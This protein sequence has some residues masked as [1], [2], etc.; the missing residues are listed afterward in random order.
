MAHSAK[1]TLPE[2]GAF[3]RRMGENYRVSV[4]AIPAS[5]GYPN[6]PLSQRLFSAV[7][8]RLGSW[9]GI[10]LLL[11]YQRPLI[12]SQKIRA[13]DLELYSFREISA[14]E[15]AIFSQDSSLRLAK[16][17]VDK[18]K[19]RGDVCV[20]VFDGDQLVAYRWY[21]LSGFAPCEDNL[22]VRNSDPCH[23]Y[24]Y[25]MYTEPG[26]RGRRLQLSSMI[27]G[28][29]R[30]IERGFTHATYYVAAHNISS[31][32]GLSRI[33]DKKFVGIVGNVKL[34]GH[35][36]VLN[37]PNLDKYSFR[38]ENNDDTNARTPTAA[39]NLK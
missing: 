6:L 13:Q 39:T 27:Y 5:T 23:V 34:L 2:S 35:N 26:H 19:E 1:Q 25:K 21:A 16:N 15:L 18:A 14:L 10:K 30:M 29:A 22:R 31:R 4:G 7:L 17:F 20:G 36:F 11:I 12:V 3:D 37:V 9:C 33:Q 28:D 38:I 8:Q 24:G 32:R